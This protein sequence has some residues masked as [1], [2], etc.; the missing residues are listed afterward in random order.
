MPPQVNDEGIT[1]ERFLLR[2][3]LKT[4]VITEAGRE[5][6]TTEAFTDSTYENSCFVADEIPIEELHRFLAEQSP[7]FDGESAFVRIPVS[8]VREVNF[9][10]ERRPDEAE[11]CTNP[12]AHVVVGPVQSLGRKQYQNAARKIVKNP[13]VVIVRHTHNP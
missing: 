2:A 12:N 4:W 3:L 8:V 10:I 5:R 1:N 9:I 7:E 13:D 6:A 11:G